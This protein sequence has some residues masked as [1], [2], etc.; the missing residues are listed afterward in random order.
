MERAILDRAEAALNGALALEPDQIDGAVLL[1]EL[2]AAG[3]VPAP[4]PD[5]DGAKI[6]LEVVI[7]QAAA[8]VAAQITVANPG[9][10]MPE[11]VVHEAVGDVC[12]LY[13]IDVDSDEA[14]PD[15]AD[16]LQRVVNRQHNAAVLL[17]DA[18]LELRGEGEPHPGVGPDGADGPAV[19]TARTE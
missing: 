7:W 2:R 10:A 15:V 18:V 5:G 17:A 13:G 12:R 9:L 19:P 16:M 3:M 6:G 14:W 11:D 4:I 8:S 1:R